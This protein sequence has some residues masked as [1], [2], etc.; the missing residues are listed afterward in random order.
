MNGMSLFVS[1]HFP[2]RIINI[3]ISIK[4]FPNEIFLN[5][6]WVEIISDLVAVFL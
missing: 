1:S 4:I 5:N 2:W 3:L 6:I